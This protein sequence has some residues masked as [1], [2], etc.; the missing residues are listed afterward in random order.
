MAQE[1]I[2]QASEGVTVTEETVN[3]FSVHRLRVNRP[4]SSLPPVGSYIT[5]TLGKLWHGSDDSISAAEELISKLL[6]ELAAPYLTDKHCS[7]L[8]VCLGNRRI[9]SDAVG[10]ICSEDLIVT[11]H[12]KDE[13][14][15][16][17][18][19]LGETQ[20]SALTPGVVGETGIETLELVLSAASRVKPNVIIAIDALAAKG[21]D[22][23]AT[24]VQLSDAGI[25]PGSGIGNR[26]RG[27]GRDTLGVPVISVGIPTVVHS[28]TLIWNTL[29]AAGIDTS[30][31]KLTQLLE[32][33]RSFFV[34]P[35]DVDIA[36]EFLAKL[37]AHAVNHAF[38]G[39][40]KL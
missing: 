26:R 9:I 4:L 14:P 22:R 36:V 39:I 31:D 21:I 13:F 33:G 12:L 23:L 29:E 5:V 15:R 34:S 20:L 35:T 38:L 3:G 37:V 27:L 19:A 10:P 8:A 7:V 40:S 2:T 30:S 16:L 25:S 28:S 32:N 24:A 6:L 11:R 17:Y 1:Q 18:R